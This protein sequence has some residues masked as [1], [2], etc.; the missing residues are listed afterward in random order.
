M[1][2]LRQEME[3]IIS[4]ELAEKAQENR[5]IDTL[6][7]I[8]PAVLQVDTLPQ[9]EPIPMRRLHSTQNKRL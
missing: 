6:Y 8:E 3:K 7:P 2:Y 4:N 9:P 5:L 1:S